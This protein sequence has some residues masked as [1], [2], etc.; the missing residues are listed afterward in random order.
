[1]VSTLSLVAFIAATLGAVLGIT[2]I[3]IRGR[4][5]S[6]PYRGWHALHHII[7]LVATV[8]VLTWSFSGW[9]SIGSRPAVL[10]WGADPTEAG[11]VYATPDWTTASPVGQ[12][13]AR[14][15]EWFA[16]S[17][18]VYR[19]NRIGLASQTLTKTAEASRSGP[20]AFLGEKDVHD[21]TT[22]LAPDCGAPSVTCRQ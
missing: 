16:V 7:G 18:V 10:A 14:E 9:L 1:M 5:C 11:V 13:S 17:G 4:R 15:V 21:L 3:R 20:V 22:R 6:S 19:R 2:R 8:F 12:P